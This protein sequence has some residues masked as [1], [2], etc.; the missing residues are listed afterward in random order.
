[1]QSFNR[2]L[3]GIT[4]AG[5]LAAGAVTVATPAR[6]A[7][8]AERELLGIRLWNT[9]N[10]VL[11]KYGPPT[12]VENGLALPGGGGGGATMQAGMG[13]MGGMM[14]GGAPGGMGSGG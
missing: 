7:D 8:R 2:S 12:R 5:L 11:A 14:M 4:A 9:F 10:N 6:A 1:M 3:I 13:G